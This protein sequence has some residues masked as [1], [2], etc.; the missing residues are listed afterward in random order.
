MSSVASAS[1]VLG[2]SHFSCD[3]GD[4]GDSPGYLYTD[5]GEMLE[6]SPHSHV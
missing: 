1:D 4:F 3:R 2:T 6:V 5:D